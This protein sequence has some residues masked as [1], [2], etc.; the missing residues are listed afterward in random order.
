[1][2]S[3]GVKL[4]LLERLEKN[5]ER[6][7]NAKKVNDTDGIKSNTNDDYED[8]KIDIHK[9]LIKKLEQENKIGKLNNDDL[10]EEIRAFSIEYLTRELPDISKNQREKIIDYL[11]DEVCG[12]GPI[13]E[14]INQQDIEEIMVNGPYQIYIEKKG[15]G[16]V[17][18]NKKFHDR[19]HVMHII[20][21]IISPLGK[22]VDENRP[23]T[24]ARLP[25]GSRVHVIIPP[26]APRGP[27]VS[28][29]KFETDPFTLDDLISF[30][31]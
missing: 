28:I 4:S 6:E 12:Y 16:N 25:D 27:Y 9:L 7:D 11:I 14:F 3:E 31:T 10:K 24:N 1:M 18:T 19:E 21:K 5:K 13:T 17:L 15:E 22:R 20:D 8:I 23:Y 29:R 30:S 2:L 26:V